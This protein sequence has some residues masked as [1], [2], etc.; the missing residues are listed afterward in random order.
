[1]NLREWAKA[2]RE[3]IADQPAGFGHKE[4]SLTDIEEILRH[5]SQA[6]VESLADG[7]DLHLNNLAQR[8]ASGGQQSFQSKDTIHNPGEKDSS[9]SAVGQIS[10]CSKV[11]YGYTSRSWT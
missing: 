10:D 11:K 9:L 1:M 4:F 5:S 3:R 7:E 2:T 8:A 6:L